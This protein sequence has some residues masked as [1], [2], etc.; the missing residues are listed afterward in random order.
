MAG[1]NT[2]RR[3]A[4]PANTRCKWALP[5]LP[6]QVPI[7]MTPTTGRQSFSEGCR[8]RFESQIGEETHSLNTIMSITTSNPHHQPPET[9]A[10][11]PIGFGVYKIR[12]EACTTA[13]LAAFNAGYRH[14]DTAQLYRNEAH[15]G[16]AVRKSGISRR[17]IFLTTKIGRKEATAD[18]T[19]Q[20]A[21]DSVTRLASEDGY[22]DLFL[23]HIP[24]FHR[25][26]R[27]EL[28]GV[29]ERLRAEGKAKFIGVSNYRAY[30]IEEMKE[31]ATVWP[32]AVNQIEVRIDS[33]I[34]Y[35]C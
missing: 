11:P 8:C 14:V 17:D 4:S 25:V 26:F 33:T 34:H 29:L 32:P 31:Y 15:V 28:W 24:G 13:C 10:K 21:L 3:C 16:E 7:W 12:G 35:S 2:A 18:K 22:V 5:R 6:D 9:L 27:E 30:H 1:S 20:S 19:Y 23:I